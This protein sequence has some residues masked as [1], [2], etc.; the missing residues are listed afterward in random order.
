MLQKKIGVPEFHEIS[1]R[2]NSF[3]KLSFKGGEG[4]RGIVESKTH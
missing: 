2:L 1:Y 4:G 3:K